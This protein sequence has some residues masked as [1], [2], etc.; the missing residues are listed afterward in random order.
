MA[1]AAV[2]TARILNRAQRRSHSPLALLLACLFAATLLSGHDSSRRLSTSAPVARH[3]FFNPFPQ[4]APKQEEGGKAAPAPEA[5]PPEAEEE[6]EE[7]EQWKIDYANRMAEKIRAR[8][9]RGDPNRIKTGKERNI[10]LMKEAQWKAAQRKGV[11]SVAGDASG[12]GETVDFTIKLSKPLGLELVESDEKRVYIRSVSP[13]GSAES[14]GQVGPGDWFWKINGERVEFDGLES[15]GQM[16]G[17]NE[18]ADAEGF[19]E[20]SFKRTY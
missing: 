7:M 18:T 19:I 16:I 10:K 17:K 8:Q 11:N 13:G 20:F 14:D 4:E 12:K 6:Y 15:I 9:M 3:A 5:P 1:A 2:A